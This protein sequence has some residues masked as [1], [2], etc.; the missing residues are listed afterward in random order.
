MPQIQLRIYAPKR[1][2][3]ASDQE[4]VHRLLADGY[5]VTDLVALDEKG[6]HS[7][8]KADIVFTQGLPLTEGALKFTGPWEEH[9]ASLRLLLPLTDVLRQFIAAHNFNEGQLLMCLEL[10]AAFASHPT[11]HVVDDGDELWWHT[12][13]A[14]SLLAS[15]EWVYAER[16]EA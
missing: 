4:L 11:L 8:K 5:L 14:E 12:A 1:G 15:I 6:N 3:I 13:N 9:P 2:L 10:K 7:F 16:N